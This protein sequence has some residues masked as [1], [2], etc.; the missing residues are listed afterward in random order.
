MKPAIAGLHTELGGILAQRLA[1]RDAKSIQFNVAGQQ[2]NT[3]LHDPP[4]G[5]SQ[6]C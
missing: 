3:L 1:L 6:K 5:Q 2:A 4:I